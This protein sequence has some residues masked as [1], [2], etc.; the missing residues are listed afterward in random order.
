MTGDSGRPSFIHLTAAAMLA[1]SVMERE[2]YGIHR[3][4]PRRKPEPLTDEERGERR[5]KAKRRAANKA[6]RKQ[7]RKS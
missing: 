6:A 3:P 7:R 5:A 2:P 1:A 4:A